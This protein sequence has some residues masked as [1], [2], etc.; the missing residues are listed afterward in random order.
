MRVGRWLIRS[1]R[2][3]SGLPEFKTSGER[4][5]TEA[6]VEARYEGTELSALLL[7]RE[8]WERLGSREHWEFLCKEEERYGYSRIFVERSS[9]RNNT[10]ALCLRHDLPRRSPLFQSLPLNRDCRLHGLCCLVEKGQEAGCGHGSLWDEAKS[11]LLA[12]DR[13][14]FM[15]ARSC[16]LKRFDR[17]IARLEA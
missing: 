14:Q 13:K 17:A 8:K 15:R 4:L 7:S 9:I 16:L 11:A 1:F 5:M 10:C 3:M 6:E 12:G 2:E